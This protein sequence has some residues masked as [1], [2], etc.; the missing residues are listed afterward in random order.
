MTKIPSNMEILDNASEEECVNLSKYYLSKPIKLD[1]VKHETPPHIALDQS[2]IQVVASKEEL[3]RRISAFCKRKRDE[4]DKGNLLE[5]CNLEGVGD[6][7]AR[8]VAV[9]CRKDGSK[10]HLRTSSVKNTVGPHNSPVIVHSADSGVKKI[11]LEIDNPNLCS[12][13]PAPLENRV[14]ELEKKVIFSDNKPVHGDI[15]TRLKVLEDRIELLEGISPEYCQPVELVR[16]RDKKEWQEGEIR[17]RKTQV[18][19]SLSELDQRICNLK[20][21]LQ[22]QIIKAEDASD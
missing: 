3:N 15:Y 4:L 21:L 19:G 22:T 14:S 13:L 8:V 11:K 18:K 7:C 2:L 1:D 17:N 20:N 5:F 9:L 10:S 12:L 6:S 16:E